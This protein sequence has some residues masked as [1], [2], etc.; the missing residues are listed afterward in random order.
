ML[1]DLDPSSLPMT[2]EQ[3]E[4][5]PELESL[6]LELVEGNLLV[7]NAAQVVW[8]SKMVLDVARY[9]RVRS[10][11]VTLGSGSPHRAAHHPHM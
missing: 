8:H 2:A 9:F 10:H 11:H 5:L 4:R 7:M 1:L 6:R 3:F